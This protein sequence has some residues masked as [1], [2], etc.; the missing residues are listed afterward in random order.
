MLAPES[1]DY[2]MEAGQMFF[3]VA[4]F[5]KISIILY[6]C[7]EQIYIFYKVPRTMGV[8]ML[9]TVIL[10]MIAF[11]A[12]AFYPDVKNLLGLVGGIMT[13][14]LGYSIPLLLKLIDLKND[15]SR[16]LNNPKLKLRK[17]LSFF[18]HSLLLIL[19]LVIQ[20]ASTYVSIAGDS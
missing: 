14:S 3:T 1:T 8:H 13:G 19:V 15:I 20:V 17:K 7:R 11:G 18:C 9:I 12:P 4:A 10:T 6:P 16:Q 5:L 2:L